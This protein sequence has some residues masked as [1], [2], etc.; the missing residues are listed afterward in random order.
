M[1]CQKAKG[2]TETKLFLSRRSWRWKAHEVLLG[3]L[4]AKVPTSLSMTLRD[5]HL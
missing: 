2:Q 4:C 1:G 3:L 5:K